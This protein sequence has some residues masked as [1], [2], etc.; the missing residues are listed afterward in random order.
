MAGPEAKFQANLKKKIKTSF[1]GCYIHKTECNERQ[2]M[3]DLLVTYKGRCG[4]LEC[5]RSAN[6]SHRPNQDYY[7]DAINKD[8]GFARFIYP[9]NEDEVLKEM[10]EY[11][12]AV[13]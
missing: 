13:E 2:G 5:K 3:P 12:D 7:V 11:F 1:E 9:E 4:Y 8:G 6:A 10:E